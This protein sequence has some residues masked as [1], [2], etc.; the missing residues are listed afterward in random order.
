[1][2]TRDEVTQRKM[3][4]YSDPSTMT[5]V[6][7]LQYARAP[8]SARAIT[9]QPTGSDMRDSART[10]GALRVQC[11]VKMMQMMRTVLATHEGRQHVRAYNARLRS[12]RATRVDDD[13]SGVRCLSRRAAYA[14]SVMLCRVHYGS[15]SVRMRATPPPRELFFDESMMRRHIYDVRA[16]AARYCRAALRYVGRLIRI[17]R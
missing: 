6:R 15:S 17:G 16:H 2:M 14:R 12:E 8:T 4:R 7:V 5:R 1:M 3:L 13:L 9:R 10:A 11:V